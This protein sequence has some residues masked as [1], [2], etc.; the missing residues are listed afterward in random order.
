VKKI[1]Y[2]ATTNAGKFDEVK[3]YFN[4]NEPKIEL[5]QL[6]KDFPEIQT[7]DQKSIAIDKATQAWNYIKQPVLVDDAAIYFDHYNKF[8]GT[9]TKFVFHGIGFEG[10]LKLV[11]IDNRATKLLYM[12]YKENDEEQHIFEGICKGKIIRPKI[13]E[14]HPALPYDAIFVPDETDKTMYQLRGT[15]EEHKYAY[16][17]LAL[18]KFLKWHNSRK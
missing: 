5:K 14:S 10:L 12:V 8:P 9:L 17:L 2:Y 3:R 6:D 1:I 7:V 4:A 11:E 15:N 18:E 16:R 13:F